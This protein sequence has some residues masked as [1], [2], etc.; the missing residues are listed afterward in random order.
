MDNEATISIVH[1][2]ILHDQTNH[3]D[4][5][6]HC[7]KEKNDAGVTCITYLLTMEQIADVLTKGLPKWQF[8]KLIDRLAMLLS[9]N[10][11]EGDC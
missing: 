5:H 10:H 2:P 1:N 11:L 7:I 9:S 3:I 8:I 4:V 6:K